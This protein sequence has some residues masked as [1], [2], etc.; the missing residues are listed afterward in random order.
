RHGPTP[1][2][3]WQQTILTAFPDLEVT[4]EDVIAEGDRV[5][6]R[7]RFV[8]TH[9]GLAFGLAPTHQR[10]TV[11]GSTLFA[12]KDG[13]IV[14]GWDTWNLDGLFAQLGL[15]PLGGVVTASPLASAR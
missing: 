13:R 3:A 7:W 11:R 8:A 2:K 4:L 12:F 9:A 1:W 6:V 5:A 10:V 15:V 14:E